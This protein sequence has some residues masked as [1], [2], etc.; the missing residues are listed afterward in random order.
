MNEWVLQKQTGRGFKSPLRPQQNEVS[1][2]TPPPPAG[3]NPDADTSRH[4]HQLAS[5][6]HL[7]QSWHACRVFLILNYFPRARAKWYQARV[8]ER[9]ERL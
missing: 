8:R 1:P 9:A 3:W 6:W 5:R 7:G 4:E 2:Y